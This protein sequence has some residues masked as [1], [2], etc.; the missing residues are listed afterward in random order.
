MTASWRTVSSGLRLVQ[1]G[2]QVV[3][4]AVGAVF[5]VGCGGT[6]VYQAADGNEI[7]RWAVVALLFAALTAI[8]IGRLLCTVGRWVCLATPAEAPKARS[9]ICLTV[10]FETCGLLSGAATIALVFAG[11]PLPDELGMI[12]SGFWLLTS[13]IGRVCFF[14]FAQ[15]V[16]ETVGARTVTADANRLFLTALFTL[17]AAVF[18]PLLFGVGAAVA[19]TNGGLEALR[20]VF[21]VTGC[22]L[23]LM[24]VVLGMF[25]FASHFILLAELRRVL[26]AYTPAPADDDPD[27]EYRERYIAGG[28]TDRDP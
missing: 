18:G 6:A 23:I 5:A 22:G 10:I 25:L 28:G 1:V 21:C 8:V 19:V 13:V 17:A 2:A 12:G 7:V 4:W 9:R 24:A 26:A 3:A 15:A 14:W 20:A 16:G 11:L 27:R